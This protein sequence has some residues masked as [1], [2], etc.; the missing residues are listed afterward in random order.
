MLVC[1]N[2]QTDSRPRPILLLGWILLLPLLALIYYPAFNGPF[3]LDDSSS[4]LN[5]S[6]IRSISLENI[7]SLFRSHA[8]VRALDHHPVPG[9]TFLVDYQWAGL[10]PWAYRVTNLLIHWLCAGAALL[11]LRQLWPRF[12]P[13]EA[14]WT[15]GPL[16]AVYLWALHPFASMPVSYITCRQESLMVLGCI[17]SLWLLARGQEQLSLLAAAGAFL[18]KEVA[19]TLPFALFAFEWILSGATFWGTFRSRPRYFIALTTAWGFLC[20]WHLKGGRRGHVM[21][22]G[23]PLATWQEYFKAQCGV[24]FDYFVKFFWPAKLQFYPWVTQVESWRDWI[25]QGIALTALF[26]AGLWCLWRGSRWVGF[27]LLWPFFILGPTSSFIPIPY[28]PAMEYRMYLPALPLMALAAAF[29]SKRLPRQLFFASAAAAALALAVTSHR[30]ARDYET[31]VILYTKQVAVDPKGLFGWDALSGAYYGEGLHDKAAQA[32]W[33]T[34]DLALVEKAPDFLG[35]SF[36]TLG[37]IAMEKKRDDE[38]VDYFRR[39]IAAA[40]TWSSKVTL[41]SLL[42][43]RGQFDE[44]TKLVE[45]V[46]KIMPDRPDALF[47][48]YE[49]KMQKDDLAGAEQILD[50]LARFHPDHPSLPDQQVRLMRRKARR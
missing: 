46:L 14:L 18:S 45:D 37:L 3:L 4:I 15:W 31:G 7:K 25:P 24:V 40:G 10:Q 34:I 11:L 1:K 13:A 32:A 8:D 48:L 44:A 22:T 38:A 19:V 50:M 33:K 20:L 49:S 42:M 17:A 2:V 29:L 12:T 9:L 28:E 5:N 16:A 27:A 36:H 21:A 30:R 41:A 43:R 23:M 35:R 47:L 39:G 6:E 26:G